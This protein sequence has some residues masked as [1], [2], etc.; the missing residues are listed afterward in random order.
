MFLNSSTLA[1]LRFFSAAARTGSFKRAAL[2]LHVTQGAVSQQIKHLEG[3]LG[4]KLFYRWVRRVTLTEEG[5]RFARVVEGSLDEIER[6]AHAIRSLQTSVEIRL[7]A[8]PSFALRWLVPRLGDF[9]AQHTGLRL[10]INAAYGALDLGRP[11]FDLA[12][13]RVKE[14]IPGIYSERLMNEFLTPICSS[15]YLKRHEIKEPADLKHC[16]LLHDAQPW[17]GAAEDAEWRHWLNE[18]ESIE[19]DS[20]RGQFFSL[21]N[22]AV[23]AALTHQGVALGR[24]CL[25]K[26]LLEG[27]RL[28]MPFKMCVSS[29]TD[30]YLVYRKEA[31]TRPGMRNVIEWLKKKARE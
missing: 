7:R 26:D 27:G 23:E 9:Y 1:S 28:V 13:E 17:M 29:P 16:T 19:V 21:S 20:S 3:A 12:I 2:D 10:F 6:E 11:E 30:Y 4:V 8:G 31:G 15:S 22:M 5:E 18:V 14:R 24:I 25:I